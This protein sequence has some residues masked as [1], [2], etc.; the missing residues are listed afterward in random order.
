MFSPEELKIVLYDLTDK[1]VSAKTSKT[2]LLNQYRGAITEE[3][4]KEL[5]K[6]NTEIKCIEDNIKQ[7]L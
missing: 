2:K 3:A 6:L 7:I 1:L 4:K 5:D